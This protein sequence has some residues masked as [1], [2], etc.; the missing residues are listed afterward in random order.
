M[1][2]LMQ[3]AEFYRQPAIFDLVVFGN[4]RSGHRPFDDS[5]AATLVDT[6]AVQIHAYSLLRNI[7]RD[8]LA[9]NMI[10]ANPCQIKSMGA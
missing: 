8:A 2:H 5:N 10:H 3:Y 4:R 7:M 1:I 6:P 9:D